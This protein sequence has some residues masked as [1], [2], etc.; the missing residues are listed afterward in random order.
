MILRR[1]PVFE[2]ILVLFA[3]ACLAL[4]GIL[5]YRRQLA[6]APIVDTYSSYDYHGGGYRAWYELLQR[7]GVRIERFD[8]RPGYLDESIDTFIAA[9]SFPEFLQKSLQNQP[10]G[11]LSDIDYVA[12]RDWAK[13][14]GNLIWI[15]DGSNMSRELK[16]PDVS[17]RGP[18]RDEAVPIVLSPL[19]VGVTG[20]LGKGRLRAGFAEA[21]AVSPLVADDTG[22]VLSEYPLGKGRVVLVT[23]PS[24]FDNSRLSQAGNARLAYNLAMVG[25]TPRGAVAFD[26]WVHGYMGGDT[27]WSILPVPMRWALIVGAAAVLLL[28]VGTMLR[29]GPTARLPVETERTGAEYLASMATLLARGRAA[30]KALAD[31]V[32]NCLRDVAA[33][34]GLPEG[35]R[36]ASIAQTLAR[37]VEGESW[38]AQVIELDRMRS[39]LQP[40]PGELVRAAQLCSALRKEFTRYEARVG[41]GRRRTFTGRAA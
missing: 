37:T 38:A 5:E 17:E 33:A 11:R 35:A 31:L 39:Y 3:M 1:I 18:T 30:R 14:G 8:R 4:F 10:M 28:L 26:E 25:H 20:V 36:A 2:I 7:E 34:V 24:L 12:L 22:A 23:D 6:A 19:T 41:F 9:P 29:F 21:R 13:R 32:D 40:S 15:T 16:L 27:W